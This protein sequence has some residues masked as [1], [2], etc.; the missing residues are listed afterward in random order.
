MKC[1]KLLFIGWILFVANDVH[2]QQNDSLDVYHA[3]IFE[4][5]D[6]ASQGE[7]AMLYEAIDLESIV[8]RATADLEIPEYDL[9]MIKMGMIEG[10]SREIKTSYG[11]LFDRA[12]RIEYV[13]YDEIDEFY[14]IV[15]R[16]S[17]DFGLNYLSFSMETREDSVKIVDIYPFVS[18]E[19]VSESMNKTI[20]II[21]KETNRSVFNNLLEALSGKEKEFTE[22]LPNIVKIRNLNYEGKHQEARELYESLPESVQ[23]HKY[24][25]LTMTNAAA[26]LDDSFYLD[27]IERYLKYYPDDPSFPLV[28][29]DGYLLRGNIQKAQEMIDELDD[30]IGGDPYLDIFRGNVARIGGNDEQASKYFKKAILKNM[31]W[32]EAYWSLIEIYLE[33]EDYTSV[34]QYLDRLKFVFGYIFE[35]ENFNAEP[36]LAF[37]Q[38]EEFA[39]WIN[40]EE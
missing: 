4:M 20:K 38:S 23:N 8:D 28:A 30:A 5:L 11:A 6:N 19:Y 39:N 32:E 22:N 18:G 36:Y 14:S 26:D 16:V 12:D 9:R 24:F 27:L 34:I 31:Y 25:I 40:P 17:G 1:L 35:E 2:G 7:Y 33:E 37:S 21:L 3:Y 13:N 15:I 29:I 10:A